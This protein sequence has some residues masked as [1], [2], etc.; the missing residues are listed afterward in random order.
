MTWESWASSPGFWWSKLGVVFEGTL[1]GV[2]V[3]GGCKGSYENKHQSGEGMYFSLG[4]R[5]EPVPPILLIEGHLRARNIRQGLA[6]P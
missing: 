6:A 1:F 2:V 3:R 5:L 4:T